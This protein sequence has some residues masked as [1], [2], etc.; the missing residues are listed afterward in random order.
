MT[1][2][3]KMLATFIPIVL[4]AIIV[5]A[6]ISIY[7]FYDRQHKEL[8]KDLRRALQNIELE[9]EQ[10]SYSV[11]YLTQTAMQQEDAVRALAANDRQALLRLSIHIKRLLK[12]DTVRILNKEGVVQADSYRQTQYGQ[13]EGD[14]PGL[15]ESL[16]GQSVKKLESSELG[17]A[18][19]VFSPIDGVHGVAGVI[20][21]V[22]PL[23]LKFLAQIQ[24]IHGI[25]ALV[26]DG[27]RLQATTFTRA[28]ILQ[29]PGLLDLKER[30]L[31]EKKVFF[32]E[33]SLDGMPYFVA[34]RPVVSGQK[35]EGAIL[36]AVSHEEIHRTVRLTVFALLGF[37]VVVGGLATLISLKTASELAEPLNSLVQITE[38]IANG[39]LTREVRVD[40]VGEIR[41]LGAAFNTMT[42]KLNLSMTSIDNLH[43][44]IA[45]RKSAEENLQK[46]NR[47]LEEFTYTVSHDLRTPITVIVSYADLVKENYRG[48]LDANALEYLD[49]IIAA[50]EKMAKLMD[51]LLALAKVGK[52][53][54]EVE[55]YDSREIVDE[56]IYGHSL[57]LA[58]SGTVIELGSLPKVQL[59]KS[60]LFQIVDNLIGNAVRYAAASGGVI[61]VVGERKDEQVRFSVSDQ[62]PGIPSEERERIFEV[63]F[64]GATGKK[65]A[66]TGIGLATVRKIARL[67]GGDAWVEETPGG[68]STFWVAMVDLLAIGAE[69]NS[70]EDIS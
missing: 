51:D 61:R 68:G 4:T 28:A 1:L 64:R 29:A 41:K 67:Y 16:A 37:M 55:P 53:P 14:R 13:Q 70:S 66:G 3:H 2:K 38:D 12:A 36:L 63:F 33:L 50:G 11:L 42:Q 69:P 56:V 52:I 10:L 19:T 17:L 22:Y 6:A 34:S 35:T 24:S 46:A 32:E 23:N 21:V 48:R 27:D 9:I 40:G 43:R 15:R 47:E 65:Q 62:G 54:K 59:P 20:E 49:E 45:E 5:T 8:E 26:Y 18:L 7:L 60:L 44:E 58:S 57:G 30:S 25:K 31:Q 39:D